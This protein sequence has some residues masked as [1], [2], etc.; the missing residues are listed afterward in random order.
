MRIAYGYEYEYLVLSMCMGMGG[1]MVWVCVQEVLEG[2]RGSLP[3][4]KADFD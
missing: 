2:G 1:G 3:Q 4:A